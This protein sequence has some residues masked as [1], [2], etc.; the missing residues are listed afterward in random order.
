MS[1]LT[2]AQEKD[3][4]RQIIGILREYKAEMTAAATDPSQRITQLE[5]GAAATDNAARAVNSAP[6]A[7]RTA[8]PPWGSG[9][10]LAS[11]V[12]RATGNHPSGMGNAPYAPGNA[13]SGGGIVP[14]SPGT[15]PDGKKTAPPDGGSGPFG[16]KHVPFR[17]R[18][19]PFCVCP[20]IPMVYEI[21]RT[22]GSHAFRPAPASSGAGRFLVAEG[23]IRTWRGFS[24]PWQPPL[25]LA[26]PPR[27]WPCRAPP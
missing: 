14:S 6:Q 16:K 1:G 20:M 12:P 19:V 18:S 27:V 24:P 23:E 17:E 9:S 5:N 8:S 15:A 4:T 10:F 7:F 26:C 22:R 21:A 3:Y 25:G 11:P 13:P 2:D